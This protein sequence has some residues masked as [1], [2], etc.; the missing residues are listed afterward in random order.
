M[1]K[2]LVA[3]SKHPTTSAP[4]PNR[5]LH[6]TTATT[7]LLQ[8]YTRS[9]STT[10]NT[11]SSAIPHHYNTKPTTTVKETNHHNNEKQTPDPVTHAARRPY[12][13]SNAASPRCA[14]LLRLAARSSCSSSAVYSNKLESALRSFDDRSIV[15]LRLESPSVMHHYARRLAATVEEFGTG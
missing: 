11:T 5:L 4:P 3:D 2:W 14:S 13:H 7:T 8:H 9:R 6:Q 12:N 1:P 10:A 15:L